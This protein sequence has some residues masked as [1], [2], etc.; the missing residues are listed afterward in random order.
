MELLNNTEVLTV[1]H[2]KAHCP[3][4]PLEAAVLTGNK[5][6]ERKKERKKG[7]GGGGPNKL[8]LID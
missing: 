6:K 1:F 2:Y 3:M 5:K 8:G 4:N 7:G